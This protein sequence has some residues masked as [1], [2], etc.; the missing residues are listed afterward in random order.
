M[1]EWLSDIFPAL[2]LLSLEPDEVVEILRK[3]LRRQHE[4]LNID[5]RTL[6]QVRQ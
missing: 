1:Q 5:K 6:G 2:F 3:I 4:E